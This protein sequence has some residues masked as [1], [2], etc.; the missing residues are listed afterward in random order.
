[1]DKTFSV[2]LISTGLN[3]ALQVTNRRTVYDLYGPASFVGFSKVLG[4]SV[5]VDL[6][7]FSEFGDIGEKVD[8]IQ[9]SAGDQIHCFL[10]VI[11][12][13]Q[14]LKGG[15]PENLCLINHHNCLQV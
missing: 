1:M 13:E 11:W 14:T 7:S 15:D 4:P 10:I 2:G 3:G 9:I 12:E 5:G 6:I 8:G